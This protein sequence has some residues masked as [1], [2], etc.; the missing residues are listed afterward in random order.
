MKMVSKIASSH[1]WNTTRQY[2]TLIKV[3]VGL[4]NKNLMETIQKDYDRLSKDGNEHYMKKFYEEMKAQNE[5]LPFSGNEEVYI[6]ELEQAMF[7][8]ENTYL[9]NLCNEILQTNY[10]ILKENGM[11]SKFLS[12][13]HGYFK[14]EM[15]AVHRVPDSDIIIFEFKQKPF[16]NKKQYHW[17]EPDK[18][19]FY[20]NK[21]TSNV[22]NSFEDALIFSLF[23]THYGSVI[24][25]R[26]DELIDEE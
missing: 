16:S 21:S 8:S 23:P 2:A 3:I 18:K 19:K 9:D 14:G 11:I 7:A 17:D 10:N 25:L 1:S 20:S 22:W 13:F 6:K 15:V 5:A 26:R 12:E 4:Y 24:A